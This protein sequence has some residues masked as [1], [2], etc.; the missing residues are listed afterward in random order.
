MRIQAVF[1]DMGGTIE[2][3]SYTRELRL[4]ATRELQA[5]LERAGIVLP[6][7][8]EE[9]L[10]LITDG[11]QRY[12]ITSIANLDELSPVQ[13]WRDYVFAGYEVDTKKLGDISEELAFF[14]ETS[15]YQREM[16][17]EMPA[18]LEAIKKM[19]LKIGL[20]SNVN[21]RGQ[22]PTNLEQ[23]GIRHYFDPIVLSSEYGRRKP[24][25]SIFH[26]AARLANMPTSA[27][28]Y[29]GDRIARDIAGAR[30]AGFALAVQ[31]QHHFEH[32]E[33]D[34][35]AMPDF[36]IQDMSE[37]VDI[38]KADAVRTAQ[39]RMPER[40]LQAVLFDAGDILYR[41]PD[42]GSAFKAFLEELAPVATNE[43]AAEKEVLTQQAYRGEIDQDEFWEG[44]L[45]LLGID[46]PELIARGKQALQEDNNRLVFMEG[47]Q[48][49]LM[50]LKARGYLLGIV[51]DT[52]NPMHVKLRWFENG[53]IGNVWDAII[54]SKE[55]GARKPDPQIYEAALKQLGTPPER[56]V[57]VGHKVSELEGA[58]AVGMQTI[59]FNYEANARADYFIEN[60]CDLLELPILP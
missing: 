53:G 16:R 54:S 46:Q 30:R 35:G 44:Q 56:A 37:L 7:S 11:L 4:E 8:I 58:C 14:V 28:L 49:T 25:P 32:G 45:R 12:K 13:V 3:F 29:V 41:R 31:I 59:A 38:L 33:D 60:F 21:S 40:P 9:L 48:E 22:V 42:K 34:L 10:D 50:A 24:D 52:A 47:V 57:F 17:P 23:Y 43:V 36:V 55:V 1:F 6:L 39:Q 5:R 15:F 18:V 27:C 51:T 20:I 2:T 26:Y 19:G